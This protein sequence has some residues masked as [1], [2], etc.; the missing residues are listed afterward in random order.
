M[1]V[2]KI[3]VPALAAFLACF[4]APVPAWAFAGPN[5]APKVLIIYSVDAS[6]AVPARDNIMA[7]LTSTASPAPVVDSCQVTN[8]NGEVA[9]ALAACGLNI[10]DYCQV[11]DVRFEFTTSSGQVDQG[12]VTPADET[13]YTQFLATGGRLMMVGE[14]SAFHPRNDGLMQFLN[15]VSNGT[16]LTYPT[17]CKSDCCC[18]TFPADPLNFN[19]NPNILTGLQTHTGDPGLFGPGGTGS[20]RP[21]A[22]AAGGAETIGFLPQDLVSGAGRLLV[23]MDNNFFTHAGWPPDNQA[24]TQNIYNWLGS[25]D[26]RFTVSKSASVPPPGTVC[27]GQNFNYVLCVQNIGTNP[28]TVAAIY[29]TFSTC[30]S[31]VSS[32]Q[33]PAV[34]TGN[35]LA[36]NVGPV[37]VGGYAC[38][39]ATVQAVSLYPCP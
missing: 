27:V 22:T 8:A 19:S 2:R 1:S 18:T 6:W 3:F 37:P 24:F 25:C 13:L 21:L 9:Q 29:D 32:S 30:V 38:V 14:T 15:D 11:W 28:L 17:N 34:H 12:T 35:Y 4:S 31:Y 5:P 23:T 36:W 39:T 16:P 26:Q 10:F 7:V 33:A 20:G